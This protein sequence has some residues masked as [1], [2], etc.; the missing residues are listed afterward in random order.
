MKKA[1]ILLSLL[2]LLAAVPASAAGTWYVFNEKSVPENLGYRVSEY[3]GTV[4]ITFLGDCT[5]GGESPSRYPKIDFA[6]RIAENG[7]DF[8]FRELK[9]LTESMEKAK[10]PGTPGLAA[11]AAPAAAAVKVKCPFCGSETTPTPE[12][13]CEFC[14]APLK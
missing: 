12:G 14:D 1:F 9:Q 11:A 4:K 2:S 3:S 7:P 8:P 10:L 6:A 13:H 5:L